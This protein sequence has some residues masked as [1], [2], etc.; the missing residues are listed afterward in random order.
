M[1]VRGGRGFRM[2]FPRVRANFSDL[3]LSFSARVIV[4][5]ARFAS[6]APASLRF[7]RTESF[8]C[9]QV[10]SETTPHQTLPTPTYTLQA[11][12]GALFLW[13]CWGR[14]ASGHTDT[15]ASRGGSCSSLGCGQFC[16]LVP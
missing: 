7:F 16:W 8:R 12:F 14:A 4:L 13:R 10:G 2:A 1:S 5:E 15:R 11:I 6:L 9:A 3:A